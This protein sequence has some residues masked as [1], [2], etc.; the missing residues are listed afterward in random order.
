MIPDG[1]FDLPTLLSF[2]AGQTIHNIPPMLNN[3]H[4][5]QTIYT[6]REERPGTTILA[7]LNVH[8]G[9]SQAPHDE[10]KMLYWANQAPIVRH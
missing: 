8:S 3:S 10:D 4:Y 6:P 2:A 9:T 7:I 5:G 1:H